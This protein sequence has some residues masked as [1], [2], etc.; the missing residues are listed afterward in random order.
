[1]KHGVASLYP[2][3]VTNFHTLNTLAFWHEPVPLTLPT[4]AER[5][6]WGGRKKYTR[7][8]EGPRANSI[9]KN[10]ILEPTGVRFNLDRF[11]SNKRTSRCG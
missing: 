9:W 8:T 1:M 5:T 4:S 10:W 3:F 6:V 2:S 11:G 7:Q